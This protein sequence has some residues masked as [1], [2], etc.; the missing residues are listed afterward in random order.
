M[1]N[2]KCLLPYG[3]IL[4]CL[5][6]QF[7]AQNR[8]L[9]FP[10]LDGSL[11]LQ[12]GWGETT[13]TCSTT[14]Q[15]ETADK[16]ASTKPEYLLC[17][18][19]ESTQAPSYCC[20]TARSKKG[21]SIFFSSVHPYHFYLKNYSEDGMR[22]SVTNSMICSLSLWRDKVSSGKSSRICAVAEECAG[23]APW[24]PLVRLVPSCNCSHQKT[25]MTCCLKFHQVLCESHGE[26]YA[27]LAVS[28]SSNT[29]NLQRVHITSA[30]FIVV[31]HLKCPWSS[32]PR[33]PE[34]LFPNLNEINACSCSCWC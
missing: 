4:S 16:F 26:I 22:S 12:Q 8:W 25:L 3:Q 7:V 31:L 28:G 13:G 21:L 20:H 2:C 9:G 24:L 10:F 27:Q 5:R 29:F 23:R 15:D 14:A 11:L 32:S 17:V 34:Q 33:R 19:G 1:D 30:S 6:S 18:C